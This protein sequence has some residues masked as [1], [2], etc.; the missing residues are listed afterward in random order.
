MVRGTCPLA[1]RKK[2]LQQ[3]TKGKKMEQHKAGRTFDGRVRQLRNLMEERGYDA[4]VLRSNPDIRW[5][6]GASRVLD[7]EVAHTAIVTADGAWLHTDSRY[8]HSFLERMGTECEWKVDM[9]FTAHPAWV[10]ACIQAQRARVVA[11]EDTMTLGFFEDL[12]EALNKRSCACLMPRLHGDMDRLRMLKDDEE[13]ELMRHAQS[14]TDAAFDHMCSFVRPGLTEL[15]IRAELEGY[16][17]SH[18]AEGLSFDS[19]VAS[20]PNGANPHAKPS[21][22]VVQSGDLVVMDYGALYGD[23]HS[24]MTRTLCVGQPSAKQREVYDVVRRAHEECAAAAT[25]GMAARELHQLAAQVI[26]DAGY[27]DYFNHGL[28]H[29]VGIQIH[30]RPFVGRSATDKLEVGSV[31]T[32]EPGIYLPGEFGIR[33]EDFGVMTENGYVPFTSSTHD[34]VCV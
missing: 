25:P 13:L 24:D 18:G 9:E 16:M 15:E 27:G 29:G 19:I 11:V 23:Y 33:L 30:E 22:R 17:L 20:G 31:F 32:I 5:L 12:Q 1:M 3:N 28:G 6:T 14:I 8:Y 26:A 10:A 34:L 7:D 2:D 21:A 4:V